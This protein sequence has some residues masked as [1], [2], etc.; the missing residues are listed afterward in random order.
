MTP[1]PEAWA[2][3]QE[4]VA[5]YSVSPSTTVRG[6]TSVDRAECWSRGTAGVELRCSPGSTLDGSTARLRSSAGDPGAQY[7][8]RTTRGVA[9]RATAEGRRHLSVPS[10]PIPD[11]SG[12]G[13]SHLRDH[14]VFF[15][16]CSVRVRQR[17]PLDAP[18]HPVARSRD[19]RRFSSSRTGAGGRKASSAGAGTWTPSLLGFRRGLFSPPNEK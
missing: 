14:A 12:P 18:V 6:R 4:A 19:D 15:T 9:R 16:A 5:R 3:L 1:T 8:E 2:C 7:F 11:R 10:R 17:H 13:G